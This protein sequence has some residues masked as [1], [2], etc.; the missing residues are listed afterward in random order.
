VAT[1]R[2]RDEHHRACVE[3]A[4]Q[5]HAPQFT[6]W[7]VITEAV[8][9]LGDSVQAV[10]KLLGK[11]VSGDLV[12]LPISPDDVPAIVE[13]IVR[14][15]DQDIDLADACL[16]HLADRENTTTVFT[17]DR[18]HFSVYRTRSGKAFTLLPE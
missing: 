10:Q 1:F 3:T 7:P 15:W 16:V 13:I 8:Y 9:L 6:C 17:V 4:R 12:I 14:Y 5:L 18:R 11:L 2:E